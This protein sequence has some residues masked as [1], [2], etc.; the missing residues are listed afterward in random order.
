MLKG[1]YV[2]NPDAYDLIYGESERARIAG[3]VDIYA[4]VQSA[5]AIMKQ[6]AIL[7]QADV[8]FSGWGMVKLNEDILST[9]PNLKVVFYGSGSIRGFVTDQ[10]WARN[11]MITSAYAANA[12]PVAEYTLAQ[13][14]FSLKLGWHY[15]FTIKET[16]KYPE[17]ITVPGGYG[18]TV[19]IISLGMI[20]RMVVEHLKS[21][22]LKILAY[23]PYISPEVGAKLGV[24][25]CS[26]AHLFQEADVVS[27]HSPWLP[28]TVGMITSAHLASMKYGA[29]FI[30]TARGAIVNEGEMIEVLRKRSD[31][32][33]LLDVTY[34]E[35]PQ[36]GSPLYTL[37]NV[38]LTPHIAGSMSGECRRM[39]HY[40]VEELERYLAGK[41]LK[42][43]ISQEQAQILA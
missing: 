5:D 41:P 29:T 43:C 38:V 8:I 21:F 37:P 1:L 40:M 4:P 2:L 14:L 35:P 24:T 12:V 19:G 10:S 18:S 30:N 25:M 42:W 6:P 32:Y 33:A 36:P 16:A 11:I 17:K 22:D 28:E 26:L 39:G 7:A 34:P 23:D 31:I 9:A 27:L 13:I 3:L 20:G 15:V